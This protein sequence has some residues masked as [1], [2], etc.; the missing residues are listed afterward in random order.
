MF[1]RFEGL[2][3]ESAYYIIGC[4]GDRFSA[5]YF[6]CPRGWALT[7]MQM[8]NSGEVEGVLRVL[9]VLRMMQATRHVNADTLQAQGLLARGGCGR[10]VRQIF[11][12]QLQ[13]CHG[14]RAVGWSRR[15]R[16]SA[17]GV[18]THPNADRR[19]KHALW[20]WRIRRRLIDPVFRRRT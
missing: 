1:V 10:Q 4:F 2:V 18:A 5:N 8:M 3:T 6:R 12:Q 11:R 17:P 13:L 9:R 20:N 14:Y 19:G 16:G 7:V 15:G